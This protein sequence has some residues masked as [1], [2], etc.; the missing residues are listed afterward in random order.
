MAYFQ[1]LD[2]SKEYDSHEMYYLKNQLATIRN[3]KL[4]EVAHN[5][6]ENLIEDYLR[7]SPSNI[8]ELPTLNVTFFSQLLLILLIVLNVFSTGSLIP[9]Y[10]LH[11]DLEN[12][13]VRFEL[14]SLLFMIPAI[15]EQRKLHKSVFTL[16][17]SVNIF[18][19]G[20]LI[21]LWQTSVLYF[22]STG[23]ECQILYGSSL[24]FAFC[25]A[26]GIFTK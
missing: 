23:I 9:L 6:R 4:N 1:D 26:Q 8:T 11:A 17:N 19:C 10:S 25:F 15:L 12:V 7:K 13:I 2:D 22:T 5:K 20:A 3:G 24:A 14:M 18:L 16:I 21:A